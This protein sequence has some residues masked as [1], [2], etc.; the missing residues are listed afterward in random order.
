MK[1]PSIKKLQ[2]NF[3]NADAK[4][5]KILLTSDEAVKTYNDHYG[6]I[7]QFYNAPDVRYARLLALNHA[8]GMFGV[9]H[10]G[11]SGER[12]FEYLNTGDVYGTTLIQFDDSYNIFVSS[13]GDVVENGKY[14]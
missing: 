11:Q 8:L 13:V 6:L 4:T 12:G 10:V 9:E 3:P 7:K 14:K 2:I 5:V 1:T